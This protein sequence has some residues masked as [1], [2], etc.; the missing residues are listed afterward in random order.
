MMKGPVIVFVKNA[1]DVEAFIRDGIGD[2]TLP[3]ALS[4]SAYYKLT[5]QGL[6]AIPVWEFINEQD[7]KQEM[8]QHKTI[9]DEYWNPFF[10][11]T[12]YNQYKNVPLYSLIL[13]LQEAIYSRMVIY[14]ILETFKPE[15]IINYVL[16]YNT[17]CDEVNWYCSTFD[18]ILEFISLQKEIE[19]INILKTSTCK[20]ENKRIN[21]IKMGISQL[22]NIII[23]ACLLPYWNYYTKRSKK[24]IIVSLL[25]EMQF[26]K[27][28][29]SS[30]KKFEK[31]YDL[32]VLNLQVKGLKFISVLSDGFIKK[33]HDKKKKN[34]DFLLLKKRF[35]Q[36]ISKVSSNP[37]IIQNQFIK[38][39]WDHLLRLIVNS[40]SSAERK[41]NMIVKYLNPSKVIIPVAS[42]PHSI[43]NAV[44]YKKLGVE[45]IIYQHSMIPEI[46]K[47]YYV[48]HDYL[49]ISNKFQRNKFLE[50]GLIKKKMI[51]FEE[52]RFDIIDLE[53]TNTNKINLKKKYNIN[54]RKVIL[55]IT[56]NLGK[57][58]GHFPKDD[59]KYLSME[60][61]YNFITK[62]KE[63]GQQYPSY[64]IIIKS[65]PRKDYYDFYEQLVNT[66][67]KHYQKESIHE[68]ISISDLVIVIG[69]FT[70]AI[71][72]VIKQKKQ[73]IFCDCGLEKNIINKM[74][75]GLLIIDNPNKL[76]DCVVNIDEY[77]DIFLNQN[78]IFNDFLY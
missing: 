23:G 50:M 10:K 18:S 78:K 27:K 62:I 38:Y 25:S 4:F 67:V 59:L 56:R 72:N 12:K 6:N 20:V 63:I 29:R 8:V 15:K 57:G 9:I 46:N 61:Y 5:E 49:F 71:F 42:H 41:A 2:N 33:F 22:F 30:I 54:G 39:Q 53:K 76:V 16:V 26:K 28:H 55:I 11:Y 75:T 19:N 60:K 21:N 77:Q 65:H 3:I 74:K 40:K 34:E 43:A 69:V 35:Y 66:N 58:S 44:A 32:K 68:L 24:K 73:I 64:S 70:D 47:K 7:I 48:F 14:K 36:Y 37:E 51:P 1:N 13:F 17:P 52:K 31:E 45:T